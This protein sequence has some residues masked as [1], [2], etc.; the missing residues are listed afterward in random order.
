MVRMF[1][2]PRL[3]LEQTPFGAHVSVA[4]ELTVGGLNMQS[5]RRAP[6]I[7]RPLLWADDIMTDAPVA[8][9]TASFCQEMDDRNDMVYLEF[10]KGGSLSGLIGKTVATGTV[11]RNTILWNIFFCRKH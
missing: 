11:F 7:V 10:M 6:H 1:G 4:H 5:L 2:R 8:G 9:R 3:Y